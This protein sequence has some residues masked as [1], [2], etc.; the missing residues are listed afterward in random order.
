M[1]LRLPPM[2]A[3]LNS[4]MTATLTRGFKARIDIK[5]VGLNFFGQVVVSSMGV[6]SRGNSDVVCTSQLSTGIS[7][8]PLGSKG[9][10]ISST[11][12]F[13][14]ETGVCERGTGDSVGVRF[15]LSSLTSG[16]AA[17]RGPLSLHVK[18]IVVH[19]K[20][21]TC[22][23]HSVTST[24]KMFSPRRVN[25]DGLSTRVTLRRL[26]SGS[27]R[28]S[29]GGVT[30]AS[31]SK[32][33][34]GGLQFGIGTSGRRTRLDSFRL[35]LPGDRLRL[36]SLVTACH[37]SRGKGLVDR[38]LRFRNNVGPSL[39]ALSSITYFTPVLEG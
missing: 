10:S 17:R 9:V 37:A 32:L 26:A 6:L 7:L 34:M 15:V 8:L 5:G 28:L 14:L 1:L 38:A 23:R 2:R 18:D 31:G 35:R 3:F 24:T 12:L 21:V 22:G 20:S 4:A 27:V 36:R 13:N 39:V 29:V 30:F 25:V 33:R 16:S 19:R 11:R